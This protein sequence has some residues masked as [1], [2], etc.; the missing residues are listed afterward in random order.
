[1][2]QRGDE[3]QVGRLHD[4]ELELLLAARVAQPVAM[5]AQA[6]QLAVVVR[7]RAPAERPDV[8]AAIKIAKQFVNRGIV[9][10]TETEMPQCFAKVYAPAGL[11]GPDG[12]SH[13]TS[14]CHCCGGDVQKIPKLIELIMSGLAPT[15]N[16]EHRNG[17]GEGCKRQPPIA[18]GGR[19]RRTSRCRCCKWKR[20]RV[21]STTSSRCTTYW[22]CHAVLTVNI[23]TFP[24]PDL[25]G[26]RP[27]ELT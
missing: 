25:H 20:Q 6:R 16:A 8:V 1:M 9:D 23:L 17:F 2:C 15:L 11:C 13:R 27:Y 3:P 14:G 5:R 24:V 21:Q 18:P 22:A 26:S 12:R 4:A 7:A 19:S 10:G